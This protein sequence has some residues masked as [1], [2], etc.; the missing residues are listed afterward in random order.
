MNLLN[1]QQWD[2]IADA[3]I[4]LLALILICFL[5]Q[6]LWK[7][8]FKRSLTLLVTSIVSI[9]YVY[10]WMY[11]DNQ[12]QLWP[13]LNWDYSTPTALAWALVWGNFFAHKA[14]RIPALVS[15]VLYL[16]LMDYQNYHTWGDM[17]STSIVIS[18]FIYW[19]FKKGK[20]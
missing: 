3:Y 13:M 16:A 1:Y 2:A 14:M 18:P 7:K 6:K 17:V 20:V 15:L 5:I 9:V 10:G 12:F 11:L 19:L 4:P 8:Q